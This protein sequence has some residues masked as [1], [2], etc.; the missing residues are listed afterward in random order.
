MKRIWLVA[1][2]LTF[3]CSPALAGA[4]NVLLII[5]DDMGLDGGCFGNDAV[6][7]PNLDQLASEGTRFAN[8]FATVS[9]CS[10]SRAA[11][12]TGLYTHQ[13]GQY[14]LAHAAHN[15]VTR[16]DVQTLP[17]L[18]SARGYRTA[19]VG[20]NHVRPQSVYDYESV[21]EVKPARS[22]HAMMRAAGGFMGAL[23]ERPFFLV[24]GFTEPH[25]AKAG[26]GND[27]KLAAK[28][29]RV[30]DPEAVKVPPFLPDDRA[31]RDDI[32]DYY[33]AIDRLDQGIGALLEQLH[34]SGRRDDTLVIFVSDNGMPF[35]GAKTNLYDAGIHLPLIVRAPGRQAGVVSRA[36]VSF[37]DIAPTVLEFTGA[38]APKD[39]PGR[40][41]LPVLE[42]EDSPDRDVV[43]ASHVMHE[44]T[45]YYP[46]R[47][48]RTRTHKLIWNLAAPL[49]YAIAGDILR[50]PT[51]RTILKSGAMGGRTLE[52]YL[53]RP[54]FELYDVA[55]DPH[56]L[57]NL[58][59][60]P[61]QEKLLAELKLRLMKKLAETSDPWLRQ[62]P[63]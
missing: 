42:R 24:V 7:T 10:P 4:K 47:A 11:L 50:S 26:F 32:A 44:I 25:R 28:P 35:P 40:S 2:C 13:N 3:F 37:V 53:H 57:K 41:L 38:T 20:K 22:H 12:L 48:I 63:E 14:G 16:D 30:Y 9:S 60:D 15:Q 6:S 39:L 34:D 36:M 59:A 46:M 1:L 52:G 31:V 61:A 54:E 8:A 62:P 18:L 51:W 23:D 43:F 5:A 27:A 49:P 33:T 21:L 17:K 45:M 58:A 29:M 56:E 55:S 19:I